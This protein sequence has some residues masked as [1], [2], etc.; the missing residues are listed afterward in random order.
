MQQLQ[1]L[2]LSKAAAK[3]RRKKAPPFRRRMRWEMDGFLSGD[4]FDVDLEAEHG[5]KPW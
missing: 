2:M 1:P 5:L 4:T 3:D